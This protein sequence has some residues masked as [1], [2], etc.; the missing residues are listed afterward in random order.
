MASHEERVQSILSCAEERSRLQLSCLN[1]IDLSK[2]K[3]PVD[4]ARA[5]YNFEVCERQNLES[6]PCLAKRQSMRLGI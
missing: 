3:K 1:Q 6:Y 5:R 2:L 4:I